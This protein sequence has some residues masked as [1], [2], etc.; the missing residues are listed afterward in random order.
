MLP[1]LCLKETEHLNRP[2]MSKEI[3]SVIKDFP[4]QK[5]PGPEDFTSEC[6]HTFIESLLT[7]KLFHKMEEEKILSN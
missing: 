5:S 2:M 3:E 6:Y 7:L 1:R 4:T